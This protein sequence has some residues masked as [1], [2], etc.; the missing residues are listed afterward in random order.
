MQLITAKNKNKRFEWLWY[1]FLSRT[2]TKFFQDN[3]VLCPETSLIEKFHIPQTS[4]RS[5]VQQF[6]LKYWQKIISFNVQPE[7]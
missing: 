4:V 5:L 3:V 7:P 1:Y 2:H 6:Y